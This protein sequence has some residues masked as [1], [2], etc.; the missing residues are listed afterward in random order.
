[1]VRREQMPSSPEA[2][3]CHSCDFLTQS[4]ACPKH[5]PLDISGTSSSDHALEKR[6]D[7]PQTCWVSELPPERTREGDPH[8]YSDEGTSRCSRAH[9]TLLTTWPAHLHH[10]SSHRYTSCNTTASLREDEREDTRVKLHTLLNNKKDP[11]VSRSRHVA[12]ICTCVC[13]CC[14]PLC[15]IPTTSPGRRGVLLTSHSGNSLSLTCPRLLC[16]R[17]P[18]HDEQ[19]QT[20]MLVRSTRAGDCV[21]LHSVPRFEEYETQ[22]KPSFWNV[23]WTQ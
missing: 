14:S 8:T 1:M 12:Y 21:F 6:K 16:V 9:S 23:V 3:P 4:H 17:A 20:H 15:T 5:L 22:Q 19:W 2:S 13:V 18:T 10:L 11:P 7:K